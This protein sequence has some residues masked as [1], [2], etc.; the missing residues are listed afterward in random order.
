MRSTPKFA[1][2]D[3]VIDRDDDEPDPML[4]VDPDKGAADT[5]HIET[6]SKTVA[7]VNPKYETDDRVVECVPRPWLDRHV[8]ER[9][10]DWQRDRFGAELEAYA[11]Q[12]RIPVRTYYYPEA[13]LRHADRPNRPASSTSQ[14]TFST[15]V[16]D[17]NDD[18][19][20]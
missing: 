9:W 14:T 17:T 16:I 7:A 8:G 1:T 20:E 6:L 2:G 18:T 4:V 5:V 3:T 15:W 11:N 10:A 19:N 12:W 13:R